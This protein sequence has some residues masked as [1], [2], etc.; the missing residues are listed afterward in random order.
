[1]P[2][3]RS[4][5]KGLNMETNLDNLPKVQKLLGH[6]SIQAT[7]VHYAKLDEELV[8]DE[9]RKFINDGKAA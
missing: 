5:K 6:K 2:L 7:L 8:F 9:W 1:M 4:S 3:T